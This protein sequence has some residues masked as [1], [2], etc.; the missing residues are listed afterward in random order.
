MGTLLLVYAC[1]TAEPEA[2]RGA[3]V[4]IDTGAESVDSAHDS[5]ATDSAVDTGADDTGS[6][7]DTAETCDGVCRPTFSELP[8]RLVGAEGEKHVGNDIAALAGGGLAIIAKAEE[9]EQEPDHVYFWWGPV[10]GA[11]A[12]NEGARLPIDDVDIVA[13]VGA[14]GGFAAAAPWRAERY[15]AGASS[16]SAWFVLQNPDSTSCCRGVASGDFTNDGLPDIVF[17]G[18]GV[19]DDTWANDASA[20]VIGG[21]QMGGVPESSAA[22]RIAVNGG[23]GWYLGSEA[24]AMGD[25]DG[26]GIDDLVIDGTTRTYFFLG[27]LAGDLDLT[28]AVA[29]PWGYDAGAAGDIDGDGRDD[30]LVLTDSSQIDVY[31]LANSGFSS[32]FASLVAPPSTE[33]SQGYSGAGNPFAAGTFDDDGNPDIA[34]AMR[35]AGASTNHAFWLARGPFAGTSEPDLAGEW[36]LEVE[37]S[38]TPAF[39]DLWLDGTD[40]VILGAT[41]EGVNG[42]VGVVTREFDWAPAEGSW[43][44]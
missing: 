40:D 37:G 25:M 43:Q 44:R 41:E 15:E 6:D 19:F 4:P 36:I 12:A 29:E 39:N 8:N 30:A 14:D 7:C 28:H 23:Q 3:D 11:Q 13:A 21:E 22:A 34:A 42:E 10:E 31:G 2:G 33:F 38:V 20:V 27:P 1:S 35:C 17:A 24:D 5:A 18:E 32:P 9:S 26:D 16:P